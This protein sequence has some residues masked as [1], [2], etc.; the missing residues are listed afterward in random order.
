MISINSTVKVTKDHVASDLGGEVAIL[1]L[2]NG[3]YYGLDSVGARVW[4][5]IQ[6]PKT[7]NEIQDS[8][9]AEY[10]VESE[11]CKQDLLSL[12]TRMAAEGLIEVNPV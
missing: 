8:I 11:R 7:V 4:E 12:F 10:D 2:K 1:N 9:L 6:E 5:L 3:V